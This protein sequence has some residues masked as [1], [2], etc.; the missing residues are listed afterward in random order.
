MT[1]ATFYPTD[2]AT[3]R[4]TLSLLSILIE[5]EVD[6]KRDAETGTIEVNDTWHGNKVKYIIEDVERDEIA[7]ITEEPKY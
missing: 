6:F 3:H 7:Y 4:D 1:T 2:E 5:Y